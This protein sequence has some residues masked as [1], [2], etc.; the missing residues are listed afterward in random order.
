MILLGGGAALFVLMLS[1]QRSIL[2]PAPKH[3]CAY[4]RADTHTIHMVKIPVG[5]GAELDAFLAIPNEVESPTGGVVYYA[6]RREHPTTIFRALPFLPDHAVLTFFHR[7]LGF[8]LAKPS[9][10]QL[11]QDGLLVLEWLARHTALPMSALVVAGRSLGSGIA[12]QVAAARSPGKLVLI[13]PFDRL[14]SAVR[15]KLPFLPERLLK[16]TF[17]SDQY[18]HACAASHC[19]LI[20]GARDRTVPAF[21]STR[22]FN[23][24]KGRLTKVQ[25]Q[26]LG[27]RGLLRDTEVHE[28]IG[29]FCKGMDAFDV[30]KARPLSTC[31][32]SA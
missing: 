29:A 17:R 11:V 13:S 9:E 10:S 1:F 16:D 31:K 12:V 8:S 28:A 23:R 5:Q 27:H 2:F 20:V 4:L 3:H 26:G 25:I 22:L 14:I 6:G 19:L 15:Q 7:G 24:W 30:S 21:V 32:L 18:I